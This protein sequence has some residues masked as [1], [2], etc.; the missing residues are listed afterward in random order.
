VPVS[1][2]LGSETPTPGRPGSNDWVAYMLLAVV[3]VVVGLAVVLPNVVHHSHHRG[4]ELTACKSNLKN[5][6]T[7]LEMYAS[8]N[9]G[10]YPS[11]L[12]PLT[13]KGI[14][15]RKLPTCPAA[16]MLT[17]RYQVNNQAKLPQFTVVCR[18]E[19]HARAYS[20]FAPRSGR[21]FPQYS[22][23]QGLIDHP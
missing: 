10:N 21:N 13:R 11:G 8:D 12:G 18:G 17:Y 2:A 22:A 15:L 5:L 23:E 16:G 19:N 14:Y 3:V 9:A 7:A 1:G 6:A 4:S 20:A